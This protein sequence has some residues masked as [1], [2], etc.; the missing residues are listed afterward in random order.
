MSRLAILLLAGLMAGCSMA[1]TYKRP[2]MPIEAN[3]PGYVPDASATVADKELAARLG[4]EQYFAD[5]NMRNLISLALENNRDMR[6]ALL[7]IESARGAY[8]IQRADQMPTINAQ[9]SSLT[10]DNFDFLTTSGRHAYTHASALSVGLTSFEIDLFGRIQSL[11]DEALEKYLATEEASRSVKISL[12]ASVAQAYVALV[13]DRERL[14]I[15]EDMLK[16]QSDSYALIRRRYESGVSSELDLRQAETSVDQARVSCGLYSGRV[17]ASRSALALLVGRPVDDQQLPAKLIKNMQPYRDLPVGLPSQVL[18]QRP[19]ILQAE[20]LL[21]AANA[22]IGAARANFF[23]R[24]SLTSSIGSMG[25]ELID[26]FG[27]GTGVWQF[28]PQASLP[29]FDG[30]RNLATLSV[31]ETQKKIAV[32]TYEKAIQTAFKEVSDGIALRESWEKQLKAQRDLTEACRAAYYLS[33]ARYNQ[34]IESYLTVL[35]SQREWFAAQLT[36]V[37]VNQGRDQN[38]I[39][40]YKVL[41]G[42]VVQTEKSAAKE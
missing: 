34:G 39:E 8:R 24:I 14:Q 2:E 10:Q 30:G 12:V 23:P 19:D 40:F 1:P 37:D 17:A 42:G 3:W 38:R 32:A 15:S 25:P 26:I 28:L 16:S 11:K 41:G 35:V 4:W 27:N 7:N 36:L 31:S 18:L 22:D 21:K 5:P 6:I 9:G 33:Q 20:H 29:I 13:G